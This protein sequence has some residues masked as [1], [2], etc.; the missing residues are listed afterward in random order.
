[1]VSDQG[2]HCYQRRG[3]N[4][5]GKNQSGFH[6]FSSCNKAINFEKAIMCEPKVK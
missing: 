1:M 2:C 5:S 6:Q 3:D 4:G